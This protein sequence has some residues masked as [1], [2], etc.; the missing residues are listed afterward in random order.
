MRNVND[1]K[2]TASL[3]W[4]DPLAVR[5][6]T[7]TLMLHDF[8]LQWTMPLNRLCPPVRRNRSLLASDTARTCS[9]S[10]PCTMNEQLPNRLNYLHWIEDLLLQVHVDP[11]TH[12]TAAPPTSVASASVR[13][14]DIGTGA[15]CIYPLLGARLNHWAFVATE[16]DTESLA[17]AHANVERNGLAHQITLCHTT[18]DRLLLE[19]LTALGLVSDAQS[20][21]EHA[22]SPA[23]TP[24]FHFSMSNPPFFEDMAEADT[25]PQTCCMGSASEMVCP[26]GEVAF[27]SHMI[28]DSLRLR[29]RVLWYTSMIGRKGTIRKVL[30]VLRDHDVPHTRTTEFAQGRTKRWG[31]AWTFVS[32]LMLEPGAAAVRPL[33]ASVSVEWTPVGLSDRMDGWMCVV[34]SHKVLGKRKEAHRRNELVFTVPC[35]T[36]TNGD[37]DDISA[38]ASLQEVAARVRAFADATKTIAVDG[39]DAE[40]S[41]RDASDDETDGRAIDKDSDDT[42]ESDYAFL[43]LCS[44][45][46]QADAFQGRIE[47]TS[48]AAPTR[49]FRVAIAYEAGARS[50]F[51]RAA[52]ALKAATVRSGRQWRRR[53]QWQQVTADASSSSE[54]PLLLTESRDASS[55]TS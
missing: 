25:N 53:K 35:A 24:L 15:S 48:D 46:E 32:D 52:D 9:H 8:Q 47:I 43:R 45:D 55:S 7:K 50:A 17:S 40:H 3:A 33:L 39:D 23:Q 37:V 54:P 41:D 20:A 19:P 6:L 4:D 22:A 13:G 21:L 42:S 12:A 36:T 34:Q 44:T 31:I 10:C 1:A 30:A 51:W 28:R 38:C 27:I 2:R 11:F 18:T 14:M 16:I 49:V 29:T 26:G 5:E